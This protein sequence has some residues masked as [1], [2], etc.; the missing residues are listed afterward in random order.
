MNLQAIELSTTEQPRASLIILHGLGADGN[1]FVPVCQA[2]QLD[3]VGGVRCIL[4]SAPVMP[5]SINGGYEM[6]AWYDI[7][8]VTEGQRREDEAT[9]RR[10][11]QLVEALID[12][13]VARGIPP[14]RIV[15]MGFSQG[16][17]M[18]LMTGLRHPER[19][20]GLAAL[21]GY[22]PLAEHTAAERHAANADV[23]IFMAHGVHDDVVVIDRAEASRDL[24]HTLGYAIDWHTYP[25]AH[26][27]S[28][29]E[30]QDLN[31]W[32]LKVLA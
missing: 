19:L 4:P 30:I 6:R 25:I 16:C 28:L 29:E 17:A 3:A 23:P 1:D 5:V 13:E 32:L 9:L 7:Y 14:S 15:L 2:L 8:P 18:T 11:Q 26:S 24:L 10:S 21:S 27:V 20:A 22:L 31:A 12:R